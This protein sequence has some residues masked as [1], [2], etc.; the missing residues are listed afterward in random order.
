MYS[1][2][3]IMQTFVLGGV[4]DGRDTESPL[5]AGSRNEWKSVHAWETIRLYKLGSV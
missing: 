2:Y 5:E 4:I 3:L 1:S